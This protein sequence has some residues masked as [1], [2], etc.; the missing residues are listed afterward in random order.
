MAKS[1]SPE[2][3]NSQEIIPVG[4][5]VI[6]AGTKLVPRRRRGEGK[7]PPVSERQ[8]DQ[9]GRKKE[10]S[11]DQKKRIGKTKTSEDQRTA[12][13]LHAGPLGRRIIM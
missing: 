6:P 12:G 9:Q 8:E 10:R 11:E 5:R 3:V 1:F 7:P 2:P 4:A 13:A